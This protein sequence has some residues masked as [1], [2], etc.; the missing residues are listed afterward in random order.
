MLA[1]KHTLK[2]TR[3]I[4]SISR[5]AKIS[6]VAGVSIALVSIVISLYICGVII[7]VLSEAISSMTQSSEQ[8]A[9]AAS[10][11]SSTSMSLAEG[12]CEQA[13]G[14][15]QI[16]SSMDE[17]ASQTNAN[18]ENA[19]L[20]H[21]FALEVNASTIKGN[22]AMGQM[23]SAIGDIQKSSEET[24]K[25]VKTIDEIA[26]QTNLLALNAAVEAARAGEAG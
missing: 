22:D 21:K 25:I 10:Q 1:K 16:T 3:M 24:S 14:I 23:S 15:E 12:S 20:A 2:L 11:V 13:S 6:L 8:V 26:F 9:S 7:R 19:K 5:N 17:I 4:G 18:A